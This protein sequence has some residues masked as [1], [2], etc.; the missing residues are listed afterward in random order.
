MFEK[1]LPTINLVEAVAG[2]SV[3]LLLRGVKREDLRRGMVVVAPNSIE[4]HDHVMAKVYILTKEEGGFGKPILHRMKAQ[5]YTL[6]ADCKF[7][8]DLVDKDMVLPGEDVQIR[9]GVSL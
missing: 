8:I 2:D 5:L 6:T 7:P 9:I 3:G 4:T 1:F